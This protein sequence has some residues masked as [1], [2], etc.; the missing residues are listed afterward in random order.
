MQPWDPGV[1]RWKGVYNHWAAARAAP[2]HPQHPGNELSRGPR[3]KARTWPALS[4]HRIHAKTAP[5][6]R[7]RGEQPAPL[8]SGEGS[9]TPPPTCC[10]STWPQANLPQRT[11]LAPAWLSPSPPPA[12]APRPPAPAPGSCPLLDSPSSPCTRPSAPRHVQPSLFI[13]R[14]ALLRLVFNMCGLVFCQD[15]SLVKRLGNVCTNV[16]ALNH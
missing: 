14:Q 1:R 7:G 12:L 16:D 15:F 2:S 11:S 3:V 4:A 13:Y 9:S 5:P 6:L 8:F 10:G